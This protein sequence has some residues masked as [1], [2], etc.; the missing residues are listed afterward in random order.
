MHDVE[1]GYWGIKS[2]PT[3]RLTFS[4][5][6]GKMVLEVL[7]NMKRSVE[8]DLFRE[9]TKVCEAYFNEHGCVENNDFTV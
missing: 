9:F 8:E 7:W 6:T 3:Y 4:E 2:G 5:H 1:I